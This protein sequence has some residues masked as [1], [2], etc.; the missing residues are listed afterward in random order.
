LRMRLLVL[1]VVILAAGC[2]RAPDPQTDVSTED[3]D[4][5]QR[6]LSY[7]PA[8]DLDAAAKVMNPV[9]AGPKLR[10]G[11]EQVAK[12]FPR[13]TPRSVRLVAAQRRQNNAI[14]LIT[15]SYEYEYPSS[16]L[17][18]E[19][20]MQRTAS[21]LVVDAVHIRPMTSSL[22]YQ[23]RFTLAGKRAG[24]YLFLAVTILVP[25][26]MGY[27]FIQVIRTP[28]LQLKWLWAIVVLFG[29]GR[30]MLNWNT[31]RVSVVVVALQVFGSTFG[32]LG[33]DAPFV[34]TTSV[35]VGA[36]LFFIKRAT[37][38]GEWDEMGDGQGDRGP[39]P[40]DMVHGQDT[41]V[42]GDQDATVKAATADPPKPQ[43]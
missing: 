24:H 22:A 35:P 26:A 5:A 33:P 21:G 13:E 34:I 30:I 12:M 23:N 28:G 32:R 37:G 11:L 18:A 10:P 40:G 43:D 9:M 25:I 41:A 42:D 8:G 6:F 39:G 29:V 1:L 16:W 17:M 14:T 4:F 38:F 7:F 31:N 15:A 2:G 20:L 27:A 36:I 3:T 19:V